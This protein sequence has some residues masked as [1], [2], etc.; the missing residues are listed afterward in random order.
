[1]VTI[2]G[3]IRVTIGYLRIIIGHPWVTIEYFR[4]TLGH[5]REVHIGHLVVTIGYYY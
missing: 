5:I 2:I 3:N 4:S 1:M